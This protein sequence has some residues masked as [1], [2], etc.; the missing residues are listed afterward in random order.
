MMN[1]ESDEYLLKLMF[2][3]PDMG[4]SFALTHAIP[5]HQLQSLRS[6][7]FSDRIASAVTPFFTDLTDYLIDKHY[8]PEFG[9]RWRTV[10]EMIDR[11]KEQQEKLNGR[12]Y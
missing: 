11:K 4:E 2:D 3:G 8:P 6:H 10:Q 1:Y 7:L 9:R 12:S 5:L